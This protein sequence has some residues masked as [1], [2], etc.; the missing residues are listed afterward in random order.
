[1]DRHGFIPHDER[2]EKE[3]DRGKADFQLI[4]DMWSLPLSEQP[5]PYGQ[6]Y[7]LFATPVFVI[8]GTLQGG[9]S[10]KDPCDK[11]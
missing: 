10:K 6:L 1:M 3:F 8:Q 11:K 5:G 9:L 2:Y 4:I 7:R